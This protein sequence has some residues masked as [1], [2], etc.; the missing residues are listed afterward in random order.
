MTNVTIKF[1]VSHMSKVIFRYLAISVNVIHLEYNCSERE[2]EREERSQG[3]TRPIGYALTIKLLFSCVHLV[4]MTLGLSLESCQCSHKLTE[5]DGLHRYARISSV[6]IYSS[7]QD[8]H[9]RVSH[10]RVYKDHTSLSE[11]NHTENP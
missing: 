6:Y 5:V 3:S 2:R 8:I 7:C 1:S 9:V 10:Y 4:L 11:L